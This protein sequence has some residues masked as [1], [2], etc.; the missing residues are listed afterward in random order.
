MKMTKKGEKI[1]KLKKQLE[2]QSTKSLEKAVESVKQV[3]MSKFVGSVDI[4]IVLNLKEKDRKE[5]IKGSVTYP[6]KFGRDLNIVVLCPDSKV[7]SAIKAG[8]SEAGLDTLI[9]KMLESKIEY[10]IVVATPDVMGKIAK[11]GKVLGPRGLMPSPKNGTI[12]NDIEKVINEFKLGKVS[13]QSAP[14]QAVVRTKVG[15][16][17]MSVE[18]ITS[19]IISLLKAIDSETKKFGSKLFKKITISPT[20]GPSVK[21]SVSD[22]INRF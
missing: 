12:S 13:F 16:V 8:A 2:L 9:E 14:K 11:L 4:D 18:E 15:K 1:L 3:S 6:H 5:T 21:V 17:N 22:I 19:N 10:D 20:M 7:D